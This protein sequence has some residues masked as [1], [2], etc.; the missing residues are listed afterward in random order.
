M[1]PVSET[2]PAGEGVE[3]PLSE[4]ELAADLKM[5]SRLRRARDESLEHNRAALRLW[6]E[7]RVPV[8]P[9]LA[10]ARQ[11]SGMTQAEVGRRLGLR[12]QSIAAI[13]RQDSV[14]L[15]SLWQF[16]YAIGAEQPY[17]VTTVKGVEIEIPL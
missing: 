1:A 3:A 2:G 10:E 6:E 5:L 13:E 12:Q 8:G 14:R 16:L 9:V 17:L 11:I 4:E 7:S 15:S